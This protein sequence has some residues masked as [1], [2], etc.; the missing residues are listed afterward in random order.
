MPSR[1]ER[2]MKGGRMTTRIV[3]SSPQNCSKSEPTRSWS[4]DREQ[5]F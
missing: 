2:T 4:K 1:G 3:P 5:G